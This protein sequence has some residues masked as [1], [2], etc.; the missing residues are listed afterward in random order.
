LAEAT[1]Y[2]GSNHGSVRKEDVLYI[3]RPWMSRRWE[4]ITTCRFPAAFKGS[5]VAKSYLA[6]LPFSCGGRAFWVN[7]LRGVT[8]CSLDALLSASN[9]GP[10]LEFGFIAPSRASA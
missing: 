9:G 10:N 8:H 2:S 3:W 4:Q 7:L 5:N 6:V 1:I